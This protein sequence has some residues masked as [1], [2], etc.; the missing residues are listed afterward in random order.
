MKCGSGGGDEGKKRKRIR[1]SMMWRSTCSMIRC[2]EH[3][4]MIRQ[5]RYFLCFA[6]KVCLQSKKEIH[7]LQELTRNQ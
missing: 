2:N 5:A 7:T 4:R 6:K 1:G 3:M